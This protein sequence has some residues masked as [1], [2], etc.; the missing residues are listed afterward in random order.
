MRRLIQLAI[1]G[2]ILALGT[3]M[4]LSLPPVRGEDPPKLPLIEKLSEKNYTETI[5]GTKVTFEMVAVPGGTY[6][7]GSPDG[8]KG[9]NPDEGPQHPF[10]V[11]G[12]WVGKCEVTWDEFDT[13][14]RGRP[15][16]KEDK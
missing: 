2:S 1:G 4:I 5:P 3:G 12:F 14:W 6:L 11:K 13:F 7:M 9:R 10:T 16:K 8:E 15:G